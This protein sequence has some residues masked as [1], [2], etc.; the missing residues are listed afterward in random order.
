M[1]RHFGVW[2]TNKRHWVPLPD[3]RDD[4][5]ARWVDVA[6]YSGTQ[7]DD[8]EVDGQTDRRLRAAG[9]HA[10]RRS[11][12]TS[13]T[14]RRCGRTGSSRRRRW[15]PGVSLNLPPSVTT[16]IPHLSSHL[17]VQGGGVRLMRYTTDATGVLRINGMPQVER[18]RFG[19]RDGDDFV[20]A[21]LGVEI[22]CDALIGQVVV[23]E[24][25]GAP[26]PTSAR[27]GW[28]TRS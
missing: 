14:P 15:A 27:P 16:L 13:R 20:P 2:A 17:H 24:F 9:G 10:R 25:A 4:D 7:V 11:T 22:H 21:A 28:S 23:P 1:S 19:K 8:I 5:G 26:S 18:I 12:R 6:T 3:E